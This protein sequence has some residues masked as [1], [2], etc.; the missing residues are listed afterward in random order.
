MEKPDWRSALEPA[1]SAALEFL[2][3]LPERAVRP[4]LDPDAVLASIDAKLTEAGMPAAEVIKALARDADPGLNAMPSGRFFGW[5][6]GG[7]LPAAVAA[8]WLTSAW[9]QNTGMAGPTPAA[10]AFEQ[11]ALRDILELLELPATCSSALVTGAQMANTTCLAAARNRVLAAV[12]HDVESHGLIGAPALNLVVSAVPHDTV[13][14]ALR[15]LG[16]GA[17]TALAIETDA[18]GAMRPDALEGALA[19]LSGPTIVCAQIG[20]VNSGAIDPMNAVCD[21]VDALRARAPEGAVWLHADG[22]FGLWARASA[23]LRHLAAG[24]ERADSW[25]TDAH[26]WLNTPYDCG[27][28]IVKDSA[29]HRRSMAVRAAYLPD[30]NAFEARSPMD[31][32]PEFSR[33]AR[34]FA[35]YA[36]LRQLGRSGVRE[37]IERCCDHA[38][39]FAAQLGALPGVRVLCPVDLNQ[40]LVRF[41]DPAGNGDAARDD[42]HTREVVRRVQT[43]GTCFMSDTVWHGFAAMRISVSNWST[44]ESDV[45]RSVAS[46]ARA[47]R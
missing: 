38:Q 12:G 10:A 31:W 44:D 16:L 36:A 4:A 47:H 45:T 1:V 15:L 46:I 24:A 20:N 26:K 37:L 2:E 23:R 6:I 3:G 21:A 25:A 14:R 22:A 33:R 7:G 28:A 42:A 19:K 17:G 18:R 27:I 32:T 41:A 13:L 11:I 39:A 29:A 40:V 5:V 43:E 35:V 9:D 34:G 8:D 30:P